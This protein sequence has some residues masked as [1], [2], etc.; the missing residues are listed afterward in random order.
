MSEIY[1]SKAR[2][3][4]NRGAQSTSW[5]VRQLKEEL[6]GIFVALLMY[7][8]LRISYKKIKKK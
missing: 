3:I 6:K 1:F 8:N 7:L 4:N 2:I 5:I